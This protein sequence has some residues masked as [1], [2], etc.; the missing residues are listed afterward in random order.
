MKKQRPWLNHLLNFIAVIL[1][2]YLAF[3]MNERAK[4]KEAHR[5]AR[6]MMES[7]IS[8]L[9]ADIETYDGY[10]IPVNVLYQEQLDSL[11]T[12]LS[13]SDRQAINRQLPNI[14]QLENY[15]PNTST[16]SSMKSSGKLGLLEDLGLQ[17]QLN[18]YYDGLVLECIRK[19]DI[20]TDYFVD[21]LLSWLTVH[22]DLGDMKLLGEAEVLRV[23][24]NKLLVYGSFVEQK[25]RNYREIVKESQNLMEQLEAILAE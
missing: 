17:N 24:R 11:L 7:M 19:N 22:A 10:Q 9:A 25:V 18:A 20:Q 13:T 3:Y 14:F 2:V 15:V 6:V 16:Y 21:E 8:D 12:L 5:E 23:F 1:G 4:S